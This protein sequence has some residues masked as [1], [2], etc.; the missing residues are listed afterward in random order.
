MTYGDNVGRFIEDHR[1]YVIKIG[2]DNFGYQAQR[3]GEDGRG[4][5]ERY[6]ALTLDDLAAQ[7]P[8]ES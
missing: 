3:R 1:N 2:F 6:A 7:L 8:A 4:V 5:G